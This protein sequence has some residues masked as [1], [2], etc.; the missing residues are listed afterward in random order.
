MLTTTVLAVE[1]QN[2]LIPA[3][4]DIVWSLVCF[5]IIFV[6]FWKK[7]LPVYLRTVDERREAIQGG[8]E[9]AERAQAEAERARQQYEEQLAEGRAEAGRIRE[10]ARG[11]GAQIIAEM[12]ERAQV[13]AQ[14]VT[15]SAQAQIEAERQQA[16]VSLRAEVG[17]L[18]T[19]LAG[20]IVGE[21]LEDEARQRRVVDRFLADLERADAPGAPAPRTDGGGRHLATGATAA[22]VGQES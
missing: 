12:R 9:R 6:V 17:R 14:R 1:E 22:P 18:A 11:E 15:Q 5:A 19:E 2:P 21:S 8:L 7:V 16:L 20:R 3:V 10:Q 4:Y 13:E